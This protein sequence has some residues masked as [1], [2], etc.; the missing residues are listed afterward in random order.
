[1]VSSNSI[2]IQIFFEVHSQSMNKKILFRSMYLIYLFFKYQI[3]NNLS[4]F[5][6]K[7]NQINF[8]ILFFLQI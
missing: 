1:M 8:Q 4:F 6:L 3:L 5:Y 7:N 2:V